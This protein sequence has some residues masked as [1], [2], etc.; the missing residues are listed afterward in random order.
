MFSKACEYGI[1]A[2]IYIATQSI[3]GNRVKISDVAE[4]AGSPEAYTGKIMS[5]LTKNQIVNSVTGPY[6]GFELDAGKM[7]RLTVADI[8]HAIDGDAIYNGCALG[9]DE[10]NEQE[11]CPLH[12]DFVSIRN[13]L[14]Y[15]LENTTVAVLATQLKE[16]KSILFK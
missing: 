8:V 10:C 1:K 2:V 14:K 12:H 13:K 4:N 5:L 15:M 6:G 9:L 16:G 7:D 11:P 3:E